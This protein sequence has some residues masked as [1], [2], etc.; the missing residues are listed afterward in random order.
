MNGYTYLAVSGQNTISLNST[1][2]TLTL[3][4]AGGI[5]ITTNATTNSVTFN[6]G[7]SIADLTVTNSVT[8]NPSTIGAINNVVIGATTPQSGTFNGLTA[9][10]SVNFSPASA[11]V[12][13]SP[14]GSG[15]VIVNPT[16]TGNINNVAIGATTPAAAT[17]TTLTATGNVAFNGNNAVVNFSPTGNGT[18]TINPN[19]TGSINNVAVGNGTPLSGRFT[20]VQMT[21]Q[22][23][24]ANSA[25]TFAYAAALA[26]AYGM[27]MS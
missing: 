9:L 5:A 24:G 14:T 7:G 18:V 8:V 16:V 11:N 20:T 21:S 3:V 17:F 27:I 15:T 2:N 6:T 22:P 4:P 10:S 23:A 12:T 1:N 26:A 13:I 25:V 19:T